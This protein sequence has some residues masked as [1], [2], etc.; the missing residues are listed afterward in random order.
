MRHRKH[1]SKL[2]RTSEH[3]LALMRNLT[4]ALI[5]HERIHTTQV[6]AVQLR[7]FVETL[8]TIARRGTLA[9]KRLVM[10]RLPQR[11]AVVKLFDVIAP[12]V[13]ER[14]GGYLRIVKDARR[15]GDGAPMAYIEFVDQ[16]EAGT[17]EPKKRKTLKQR[18]HERRK[19][20]AKMRKEAGA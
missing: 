19:E 9:D 11:D 20:V 8:V 3:R 5:E 6:K 7:P 18:L 13:A 17:E 12:R 16:P 10:S 1:R 2:N 15:M 4:A 14:N